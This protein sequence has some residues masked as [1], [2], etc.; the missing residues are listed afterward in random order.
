MFR[1]ERRRHFF[2]NKPLQ[3]RYMFTLTLILGVIILTSLVS[4]YFGIWG[5]VLDTFSDA[6]IQNDL[7]TAMRLQDYEEVRT[8]Q[9]PSEESFSTLSLFRQ[10]E[11]MS[12]RQ[13]EVFK[14]ILDQTNRNLIGKLLLLF[15][16]LAWGTIFLSH[17]IA[18]P[19]YR[20]EALLHQIAQGELDLRCQLRKFDE[21]KSVAQAFNQAL[22][23]LDTKIAGL[24]KLVRE[25][26]KTPDRL[27]SLL[28]EEL[29]KL[30]TSADR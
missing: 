15:L 30:K 26:E 8:A 9:V 27:P 12:Q 13:Q 16:V 3:L 21:A 18:G 10:A 11:R 19:L 23:S 20:F 7:L 25:N 29:S 24:K 2:I 5:G 28:K 17:K 1:K 4:I 22:E 14:E 6:R